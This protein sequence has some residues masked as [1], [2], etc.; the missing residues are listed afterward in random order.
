M[1]LPVRETEAEFADLV[2]ADPQWLRDEFDALIAASFSYP[3]PAP[4]SAPPAVPRRG[5]WHPPAGRSTGYLPA[6]LIRGHGE[7]ARYRQRS[8][9]A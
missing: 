8:P 9:P 1:N 7:P 3:P 5:P 6:R 4:P 2:C